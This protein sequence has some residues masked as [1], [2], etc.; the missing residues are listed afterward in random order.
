M[1]TIISKYIKFI[2]T[3]WVSTQSNDHFQQTSISNHSMT[4]H[5]GTIFHLNFAQEPY[6]LYFLCSLITCRYLCVE[7]RLVNWII[8][9][10]TILQIVGSPKVQV[11]LVVWSYRTQALTCLSLI[12]SLLGKVVL[13]YLRQVVFGVSFFLQVPSV[14][15]CGKGMIS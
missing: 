9:L 8:F 3:V 14:S 4:K 13:W 10:S 5:T 7:R 11:V 1:L 6:L 12:L 2:E 15:H